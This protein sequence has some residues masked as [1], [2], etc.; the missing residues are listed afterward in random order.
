M[1]AGITPASPQAIERAADELI[2]GNLVA[3]PTETVY[4]LG[5]DAADPLAVARIYRLKGRPA[6]HPLI[7]HVLDTDGARDWAHWSDQAEVLAKTFWPGPLTLILKR[8]E[9]ACD[10]ACGGQPTIGLRAPAHPLS[11]ALLRA[12]HQRGGRGVAAP[13]ANRFGRVSPTCA[14]HVLDDLG[15]DAPMILDGGACEVG[16]ESTIVDLS[17]G[18]P[19]LLRPGG[20]SQADIEDVLGQALV[21]PDRAAPRVSGSLAAHYA[22]RTPLELVR[23]EAIDARL[24]A[25]SAR[26]MKVAVWSRRRPESSCALWRAACADPVEFGHS[27]YARLRELDR[28]AAD[29]LLI[30]TVPDEPDW[31]AVADRLGRAAVGAGRPPS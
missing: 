27:L 4:G 20:L 10:A 15:D 1:S 23:G 22:P 9:Q 30:E 29:C 28:S 16:L 19:A 8:R 2:Q 18:G 6:D 14:Q 26:G 3:F 25:L 21:Q 11:I 24:S 31:R 13:S 5:A 7:V 17:R 12:F